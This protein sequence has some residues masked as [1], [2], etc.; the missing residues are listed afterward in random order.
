MWDDAAHK[1]TSPFDWGSVQL[2]HVRVAFQELETTG[3]AGGLVFGPTGGGVSGVARPVLAVLSFKPYYLLDYHCYLTII[4]KV[5]MCILVSIGKPDLRT[6]S[7]KKRR[8][9]TS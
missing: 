8:L 7:K 5:S 6:K 3:A 9:K 1:L 2:G 4:N